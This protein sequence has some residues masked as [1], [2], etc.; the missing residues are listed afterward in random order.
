MRIQHPA[1]QRLRLG[2]VGGGLESAIGATHRFGA[3]L[4]GHFDLIAGVFSRDPVR[5]RAAA[6]AYGVAE[7]RVYGSAEEMAQRE[8]ARSDGIQAV[9]IMAPNHVHVPAAIAFARRGIDVICDKPLAVTRAEAAQLEPVVAEH[10][11]I[12]VLMHHACGFPMVRQ[13]RDMVARG[14]LGDVRLVHVEHA[15]AFGTELVEAAGEGRMTWSTDPA[16]IGASAVLADVG[17]HAHHLCRYIVGDEFARVSADLSTVVAGRG[18]DDNARVLFDM[19]RGA[20]GMLWATF[21]AAGV[22]LGL[23]IRVFGTTGSIE[24]RQDEPD[25]LRVKPQK[26]PHYLLRKGE[27]WLCEAALDAGR[28]KAGQVEGQL[29]AFANVYSDA[30]DLVRE[31]RGGPAAPVSSRQCA[32]IVDGVLGMSFIAACA[33][34]H[35]AGGAWTVI[36]P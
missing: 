32:G 30:A 31:R 25:C 13:A 22:R 6:C 18:C 21:A 29:E 4:D 12:F 3:Q 11:T 2:F 34:S 27:P 33:T 36:G 20:K 24:W 28:V 14:Q 35:A 19:G 17:V 23:Q 9:S 26:Q 8:S 7:D 16:L 10:G 15:A 5:N 1:N